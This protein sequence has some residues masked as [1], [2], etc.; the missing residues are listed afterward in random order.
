MKCP[1]CGCPEDKVVDT[2]VSKDGDAI[3]RRRE[4]MEC[5]NRFTTYESVLRTEVMV[6]KRDGTREEFCPGKLQAGIE[7]A[8]WKRQISERQISDIVKTITNRIDQLNQREVASTRVGQFAMEELEKTDSVAFVRF[9]SV[10]R[11][12]KQVDDFL[13]EIKGLNQR[14]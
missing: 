6:V 7:H 13:D 14:D 2:R 12:F 3:R 9:A 5:K 4:C 1:A 8:C 11:R 10:Y